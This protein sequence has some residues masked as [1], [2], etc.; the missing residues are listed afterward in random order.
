M[1]PLVLILAVFLLL[2]DTAAGQINLPG[3]DLP[4]I[5]DPQEAAEKS[6]GSVKLAEVAW[7]RT[8][9]RPGEPIA[10]AVVLEVP[11]PLH[12][13][14]DAPP[15]AFLIP[16]QITA[17][18]ETQGIAFSAPQFP[19]AKTIT[20]NYG[21]GPQQLPVHSG[22][23]IFYLT[24]TPDRNVKPGRYPVTVK[25]SW[26]ACDDQVCYPPDEAE[27]T[28]TLTVSDDDVRVEPD[29]PE[30]FVGYDANATALMQAES[31]NLDF[32]G[33]DFDID[34]TNLVVLL[35]LAAVGG[36]L[37]NLTPCVLPMIPLKIMAISATSTHRGKSLLYGFIM[38]AGVVGFWLGLGLTISLVSGFQATSELF[39]Q[40]WFTFTV[41]AI[42]AVMAL[43]MFGLFATNLPQWVYKINPRHD[44]VHGSFGFGVMTAVLSTPCTAPFMGAA[45]SWAV[46]QSPVITLSTFLAIGAGMALPYAILSAFPALVDRMP[47]SGPASEV[48]K[49]VMGL[50]M[51]AAGS[52][53]LG[54]AIAAWANTP[55]DP[56]S[57]NYW[58]VVAL[59]AASAGMWLIIQ[60]WRVAK[61]PTPKIVFT[62]IGIVFIA[63]ALLG[64]LR[65]TA[66][67]P[68]DWIYYTPQ[69][70]TDAQQSGK[71]VVL[72]FT[73]EWCINCHTLEQTVLHDP[74]I[75]DRMNRPEV[76]AIKVDI[77]KDPLAKQ[78][79]KEVRRV[80]I[81]YLIVYDRNGK[82]VFDSD[83]YTV[84]QLANALDQ[85]EK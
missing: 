71:M 67:S 28:V 35:L 64:G 2:A 76:A 6:V 5:S 23:P 14:T 78:K 4:G 82:A 75:V 65:L 25:V 41:G 50:L 70:L 33:L 31:L 44:T 80:T 22:R 24:A 32:F 15:D 18:T 74:Q 61:R 43:G 42:I 46:T 38:S 20:V 3:L 47:R 39:S 83:A 7:N 29:K 49:Q 68:I 85:A 69:R 10:L 21:D 34:P 12:I 1:K 63:T 56:I 17:S 79:L 77:T 53:F 40:P 9:A 58:W 57:R 72:E 37:L 19:K 27:Q 55:P 26:Q 16:T 11:Q 8:A 36:F 62:A 73:A 48:V 54:N 52:Y 60:A 81:P 51:L 45:A 13:N 66:P 84:R 30:L 59:F